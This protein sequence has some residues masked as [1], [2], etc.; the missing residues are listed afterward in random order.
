MPEHKLKVAVVDDEEL[1]RTFLRQLLSG[2]PD[3]EVANTT[4][5]P[6]YRDH[7]EH[8]QTYCDVKTV[9]ADK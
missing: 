6:E 3:L 9:Q 8:D 7:R 4:G 5:K 2:Y 1:A